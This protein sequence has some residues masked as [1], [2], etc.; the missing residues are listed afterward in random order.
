TITALEVTLGAYLRAAYHEIPAL[1]MIRATKDQLKRRA[2][3]FYRELR[4]EL[5]LNEVTLEISEGASL[6]GGGSTPAQSLPTSILRI[7][8]AGCE[9]PRPACRSSLASRMT[10]WSSTCARYSRNRSPF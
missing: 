9:V 5:P 2:E 10:A 7:S 1:E 6:V 3:N 8:S 4:P